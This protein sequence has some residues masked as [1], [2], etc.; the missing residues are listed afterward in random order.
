MLIAATARIGKKS[1]IIKSANVTHT[2]LISQLG[3][4]SAK[5]CLKMMKIISDNFT[6]VYEDKGEQLLVAKDA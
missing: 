6:H 2:L 5:P 1:N 3:T 4:N